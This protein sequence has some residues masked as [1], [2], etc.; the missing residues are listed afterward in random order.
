MLRTR[1]KEENKISTYNRRRQ[2]Q[3][4]PVPRYFSVVVTQTDPI[5]E[6]LEATAFRLS[7][8]SRA[9]LLILPIEA[10]YH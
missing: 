7:T 4:R 2:N 1:S 8:D 3:R 6:S 10:Q 5:R 9:Q